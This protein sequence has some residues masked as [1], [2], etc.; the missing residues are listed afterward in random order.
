[1]WPAV[2]LF[3]FFLSCLLVGE[4]CAADPKTSAE[5]RQQNKR[6]L[7]DI[8]KRIN[9]K[10]QQIQSSQVD[11]LPMLPLS[12]PQAKLAPSEQAIERLETSP[13]VTSNS[14][15]Q[16]SAIPIQQS[17][18]P[19]GE[20]L[21]LAVYAEQ[22]YLADIF[23]YKSK[24][25]AKISLRDLF[26]VLNFPIEIDMGNKSAKGWFIR[27]DNLF[28]FN[29]GKSKKEAGLHVIIGDVSK[30]V[31]PGS[32]LLEENDIYVDGNVLS[33]WFELNLSYVFNDL[34]INLKPVDPLPIQM[35]LARKNKK[36]WSSSKSE[37]ILPWKDSSYQMVSSPLVDVQLQHFASNR[38]NLSSTNY[39]VLGSHDLAYMNTEYY[40]AGR[41]QGGL[42]D[43]RIKFTKEIKSAEL[44]ILPSGYV[45]VGDINSVRM[46]SIFDGSLNRGVSFSKTSSNLIDNQRINING[47]IQPGWDIELYQNN[48][49]ISQQTSMQ[50]GRYEFNNIDLNFGNNMFE[51]IAYGPQGQIKTEFK[52]V[53]IDRNTLTASEDNYAFSITQ[54]GKSLFGIN[55]ELT[56]RNEGLLFAGRYERGVSDWFSFNVGQSTLLSDSGADTYNY[57]VGTNISLFERLL[58]NANINI[59]QNGD[60]NNTLIARTQW[61]GQSIFYSFKQNNSE[62]SVVERLPNKSTDKL[63]SFKISGS[64]FN[65]RGYRLN[66]NNQLLYRD[67][68]K[69]IK[70]TQ[71][72]NQL[73]LSAGRF[74]IQHSFDW[75]KT[76]DISGSTEN[77]FGFMQLQRNIGS[78]FSRFSTTYSIHPNTKIQNVQAELIWSMM[79]DVQSE[80]TLNYLPDSDIYR[81]EFGLSWQHDSF[82]LSSNFKYD[83][84]DEWSFGVNIRFAFGYDIDNNNPFIIAGPI[85]RNGAMAVRVF[86]DGNNDGVFNEGDSVIEGVKVKALQSQRQAIS[87]SDGVAIINNLNNKVPTDIVI[88]TNTLGDLFLMPSTQGVSITPRKG[89][90]DKVDYPVVTS[91]EIDGIIYSVDASGNEVNLPYAAINLLNENGNIVATTQSEYD[92]YY[93]FVDLVPGRYFVSVADDYLKRHKLKK[94]DNLAVN[95]TVQGDVISG[96]DFTLLKLEFTEGFVVTVGKFESLAML[97][98]YWHLIQRRYRAQ[99]KQIPFYIEDENTGRYSLNLAFY[100]DKSEANQACEQIAEA[101]IQCDVE[102]Y[103]FVSQ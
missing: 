13:L 96:S 4:T 60:S 19:E 65:K 5:Q 84:E 25:G 23:G 87:G 78:V 74:S 15:H 52:E 72:R 39:S 27:E 63:H 53:F 92:G 93:L 8:V 22:L 83:N 81:A 90:M 41:S 10:Y 85:A 82:N 43:G 50:T 80:I 91:G 71:L 7:V 79:S 100:P 35:R 94:I 98:V 89:F 45:E 69:G 6:L 68:F 77:L 3:I 30:S 46:S 97:K 99:L 42:S 9:I 40:L 33:E 32:I 1:M 38:N 54:Q 34:R 16:I 101:D 29:F 44:G 55:S 24:G 49:L 95:L 76:D 58:L 62:Q 11:V 12:A 103:E 2:R 47:N 86:E 17:F 37:A 20:D 28:E 59:D 31:E 36:V 18:I 21:L 61:S 66:Y 64:L 57:S 70:T 67:D 75:R 48:I 14:D 26:E 56:S 88:E 51:I 73:S 102:E